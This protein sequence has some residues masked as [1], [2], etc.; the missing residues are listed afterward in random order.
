MDPGKVLAQ[1]AGRAC[2][3]EDVDPQAKGS[4]IKILMQCSGFT[5]D[6]CQFLL[7]SILDDLVETGTLQSCEFHEGLDGS[8]ESDRMLELIIKA[9]RSETGSEAGKVFVDLFAVGR[10]KPSRHGWN[11]LKGNMGRNEFRSLLTRIM[12]DSFDKLSQIPKLLLSVYDAETEEFDIGETIRL[13]L[14]TN[15]IGDILPSKRRQAREALFNQIINP[16]PFTRKIVNDYVRDTLRLEPLH[17][18]GLSQ[19][20][21]VSERGR[22]ISDDDSDQESLGSLEDFV[23]DEESDSGSS[24]DESSSSSSN[25]SDDSPKKRTKKPVKKKVKKSHSSDSD[26]SSGYS[27]S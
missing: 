17:E 15:W 21:V 2:Y 6:Q 24:S 1:I 8:I 9:F 3:M 18:V 4:F 25:Y 16:F 26:Q 13:V 27:T 10:I 12:E 22:P 20:S 5:Q 11:Y 14:D 19:E 7:E 23:V